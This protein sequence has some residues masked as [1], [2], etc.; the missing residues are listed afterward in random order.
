MPKKIKE[1]VIRGKDGEVVNIGPWHSKPLPNGWTQKEESVIVMLPDKKNKDDKE[2]DPINDG[3]RYA[4]SDH[5]ALR[6]REY[7]SIVDQLDDIFHNGLDGWKANIQA[8]KDKHP[9]S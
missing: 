1:I 9:K 3:S 7:P 6:K 8:I 5:K 4:A 2:D